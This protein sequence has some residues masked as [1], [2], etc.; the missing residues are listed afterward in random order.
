MR[1][2]GNIFHRCKGTINRITSVPMYTFTHLE[3]RLRS[4]FHR[5][6]C[7]YRTVGLSVRLFLSHKRLSL[8]LS[9][10][11]FR[12]SVCLSVSDG[13]YIAVVA[14]VE[15]V[16]CAAPVWDDAAGTHGRGRVDAL[17][18]GR[19]DTIFFNVLTTGRADVASRARG[20][21][22]PREWHKESGQRTRLLR[23]RSA[24]TLTP[25]MRPREKPEAEHNRRRT[26][27][28]ELLRAST[29]TTADGNIVSPLPAR[30][31][32]RVTIV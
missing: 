16:P 14:A 31:I 13:V 20:A 12:P 9:L 27:R 22:T 10:A 29:T 28:A 21:F 11:P 3:S 4:L 26:N 1:G 8:P 15:S 19:F 32:S 2:I 24:H 17:F 7:L 5:N 18:R 6:I 30:E 25:L 23:S